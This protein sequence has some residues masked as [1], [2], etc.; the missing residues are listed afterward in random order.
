MLSPDGHSN[1]S[2]TLFFKERE[3]ERSGGGRWGLGRERKREG[4][5]MEEKMSEGNERLAFKKTN[6]NH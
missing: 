5:E 1:T 4:E 3:R 6:L 2:K